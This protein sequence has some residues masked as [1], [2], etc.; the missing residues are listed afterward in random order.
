MTT[1][2]TARGFTLIELMVALALSAIVIGAGFALFVTSNRV[3]TS[4]GQVSRIQQTARAALD[5]M[6]AEIKMAGF[7]T[8]AQNRVTDAA[9]PGRETGFTTGTVNAG[10]DSNASDAIQFKSSGGAMALV[11]SDVSLVTLSNGNASVALKPSTGR[12]MLRANM[13]VAIFDLSRRRVGA[14]KLGAVTDS[15]A[16]VSIWSTDPEYQASDFVDEG[17]LLI[18]KPM[19]VTY[20]NWGDRLARCTRKDVDG[21]ARGC[22]VNFLNNPRTEADPDPDTFYYIAEGV[23]DLQFSYLLDMPLAELQTLFGCSDL[24]EASFVPTPNCRPDFTSVANVLTR[25]KA[26]K[27]EILVQTE[28]I[29]PTISAADCN[30]DRIK[31]TY[32]LG[33]HPVGYVVS[34]TQE[35][36]KDHV[37]MSTIV[38]MPNMFAYRAEI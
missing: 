3:Y 21:G 14:G 28:G 2:R 17:A 27:I 38:Y 16:V 37:L 20:Q 29:D 9:N 1:L 6:A 5:L 12:D 24:T 19:Y 8:I 15:A 34:D 7:G 36:R 33:D 30:A 10:F 18:Q 11:A 4:S 35:C 26:V 23:K 22:D 32:Y 25:I 13:D 31:K